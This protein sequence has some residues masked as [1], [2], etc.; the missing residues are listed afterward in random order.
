MKIFLLL[1]SDVTTTSFKGL[2]HPVLTLSVAAVLIFTFFVVI[3]Y[4]H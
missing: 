3:F 4:A 2:I 1:L